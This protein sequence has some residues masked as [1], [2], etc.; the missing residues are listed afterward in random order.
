MSSFNNDKILYAYQTPCCTNLEII[1]RVVSV[2]NGGWGGIIIRETMASDARKVAFKT[3]LN[4]FVRR[5]VRINPGGPVRTQQYFRPN[6]SWLRLVRSGNLFMGYTS[7]DGIYWKFT[8]FSSVNMSSCV[9]IGL[10]SEG[11]FANVPTISCFDNVSISG[12]VLPIVE[13]GDGDWTT[14]EI[15]A[16]PDFSIFPNP[17]TDEV[18][19]DLSQFENQIFSLK[20]LNNLGQIIYRKEYQHLEEYLESLD[21]SSYNNGIYLISIELEDGTKLTKKL[22]VH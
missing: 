9:T 19:V 11:P 10:F 2:S 21:L 14:D 8:F 20:V 4:H 15:R 16:T 6:D 22:I 13:N 12:G 3:H 5:D 7:S 17:A 1:A 18:R